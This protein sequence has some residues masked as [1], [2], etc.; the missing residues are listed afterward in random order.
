M[1]SFGNGENVDPIIWFNLQ[2][3]NLK[4]KPRTPIGIYTIFDVAEFRVKLPKP[5]RVFLPSMAC[6]RFQF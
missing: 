5:W 2:R 1:V 4:W 6:V 3:F